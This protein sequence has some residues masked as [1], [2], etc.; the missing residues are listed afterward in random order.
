MAYPPKNSMNTVWAKQEFEKHHPEMKDLCELLFSISCQTERHEEVTSEYDGI[1]YEYTT[2][3]IYKPTNL[4][5]S[6]YNLLISD[7]KSSK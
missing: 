2:T 6:A 4:A 7:L 3:V 1:G 5:I